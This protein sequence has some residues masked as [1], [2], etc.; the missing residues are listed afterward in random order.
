M[1]RPSRAEERREQILLAFERCVAQGGA[2]SAT[3]A[4]VARE[5]NVTRTLIHHYFGSRE[6]L[7]TAALARVA[8]AYHADFEQALAHAPSGDSGEAREALAL[9]VDHLFHP[10]RRHSE[11]LVDTL[12]ATVDD[13]EFV[14]NALGETYSKFHS[15][16]GEALAKVYP[17]ASAERC[18][19]V[20]FSILCLAA[21]HSRFESMGV[22]AGAD[23]ARRSADRLLADLGG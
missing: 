3:L 18:N 17:A 2:R 7:V 13:D 6:E 14:R 23:A 16:F 1:G 9:L 22:E 11:P 20:A 12:R 19:E 8:D 10:S 15:A 4:Q 21:G 5:A